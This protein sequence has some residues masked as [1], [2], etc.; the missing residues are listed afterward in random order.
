MTAKEYLNQARH[1]DALIHCRLR[2]IDYWRDLSSNVSSSSFEEHYN[3][4]RSTEA[5]F[6]KCIEKIDEIQHDVADKAID[7]MNSRDEQLV[8]RYRY[9]EGFSWEEIAQMLCV[10]V[11][12]VH[13]IHGSALQNFLVPD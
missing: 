11:R 2:E 4:N 8:L 1:L 13:R 6:A 12:T 3:S 10:S 7:N 5:P 9:L